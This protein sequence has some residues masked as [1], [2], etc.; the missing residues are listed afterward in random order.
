MKN[1]RFLLAL[2]ALLALSGCAKGEATGLIR[3]M[4]T[5]G[6][7]FTVEGD[8]PVLI[9]PGS[10]AV[11][12][13]D[14]AEGAVCIQADSGAV[15]DEASST[16]TVPA[17]QY[18]KTVSIRTAQN[19][20]KVKF[21][22]EHGGKA[23]GYIGADIEQG[24]VYQG[25]VANI[26]T[27]PKDDYIFLGW[28]LDKTLARG[29]TLVSEE[30]RFTY[31]VQDASRIIANFA[32]KPPEEKVDI[33]SGTIKGNVS[34]RIFTYHANGGTYAATGQ[35]VV[36]MEIGEYHTFQNCLAAKDQFVREGYQLI[37]YNTRAD[38]SGDAYSPGSKILEL[39]HEPVMLYCIWAKESDPSYFTTA[40][41]KGGVAITDYSADEETVVIPEKIG[42]QPVL[43]VNKN[44]FKKKNFT[45]LV[46]PKTVKT[47]ESG[48]FDC[49]EKFTTLYLFDSIMKIPDDAFTNYEGFRNF[50]LGAAIDPRYTDSPGGCYGFKWERL[51]AAKMR[52]EKV[53]A[54]V[55]GSSTLYGLNSPMMNEYLKGEYTVVNYGTNAGTSGA[56]YLEVISHFTTAGDIIIHAPEVGSGSMGPGKFVWQ[57]YRL[58]E[59]TYN[60]LRYVDMRNYSNYF[61]ALTEYNGYRAKIKAK[62]YTMRTSALDE[63]G[64]YVYAKVYDY[65]TDNYHAGSYYNLRPDIISGLS[66][67]RLNR[68]YDLI[69]ATGA[70]MY[71]STANA[72]LNAIPEKYRSIEAQDAYMAGLKAAVSIPV[73]SHIK[74][75]IFEG[76]YMYD[77]DAH[78]NGYGRDIRTERLY[79]DLIAQMKKDG[80]KV[81]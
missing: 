44:A 45:T 14:M 48:A 32:E 79:Q 71:M 33:V 78:T 10:D 43:Q 47:V 31:V 3:V 77:S 80:I 55:A 58:M 29:G 34:T 7:G 37:E 25:T 17:V 24:F 13:L 52:G 27:E 36:P 26:F 59:Y 62:D 30:E 42:G 2:L 66:Q 46:I 23:G 74:D 22:V 41:V 1:Y 15:Y 18:P 6:D 50:R 38:G 4:L 75:S 72:N 8:N 76:K 61:S 53:F 70:T 49:T 63:Y 20:Q 19:P 69:K 67:T 40:A 39:G 57:Q 16:L 64:D 81:P 54:M 5:A 65:N 56:F 9:S 60:Q 51:V 28:T 73:I 68:V 21:Y 35:T 11:F 12:R